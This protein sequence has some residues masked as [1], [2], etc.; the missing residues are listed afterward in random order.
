[1]VI[2][3]RLLWVYG[4]AYPLENIVRVYTF[5]LT[6]RRG[7]AITRFFKRG[8]L[9]LLALVPLSWFLNETGDS[10]DVD[11]IMQP[12]LVVLSF[13]LIGFLGQALAVVFASSPYVLA[14]ETNGWST[15]LVT[16]DRH[17][18]DQ[19]VFEIAEAID[20]PDAELHASVASLAITNFGDYHFGDSVNIYGGSNHTGVVK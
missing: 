5:K 8:G 19:L 2:S 18:L 1:M 12:V 4:G 7:E 10:S 13:L 3:K 11:D 16:G 17:Q 14:I 15:A 20:Q 6:P 9:T